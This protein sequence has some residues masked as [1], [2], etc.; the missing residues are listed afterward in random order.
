MLK[1]KQDIIMIIDV[2]YVIY[3]M[4]KLADSFLPALLNIDKIRIV[5]F[6]VSH[7]G[8]HINFSFHWQIIIRK[9]ILPADHVLFPFLTRFVRF[10]SWIHAK[11]CLSHISQKKKIDWLDF[12]IQFILIAYSKT[13]RISSIY[14][15][16]VISQ[17][18]S[19]WIK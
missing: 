2:V 15:R 13:R 14:I 4:Y 6:L 10:Y 18:N 16:V 1:S 12:L 11:M 8:Y 3:E 19:Y 5:L 17:I 7:A 9:G